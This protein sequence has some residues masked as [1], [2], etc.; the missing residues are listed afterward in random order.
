MYFSFYN[1]YFR[2]FF[3]GCK[4]WL[5][6]EETFITTEN[7]SEKKMPCAPFRMFLGLIFVSPSAHKYFLAPSPFGSIF[8]ISLVLSMS[9]P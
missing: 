8:L 9:L 1:M 3:C 6:S 5:I 7:I 4:A 2:I